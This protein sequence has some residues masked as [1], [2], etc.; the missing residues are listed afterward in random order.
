MMMSQAETATS[1]MNPI[2]TAG[3][4]PYDPTDEL[5]AISTY[6]QNV[7]TMTNQMSDQLYKQFSDQQN[8]AASRGFAGS[9]DQYNRD[10]AKRT[11]ENTW[12][13]GQFTA[14]NQMEA[15]IDD[16]HDEFM[17]SWW[18]ILLSQENAFTFDPPVSGEVS[19]GWVG[20][21]DED[22][23]D[24]DGEDDDDIIDDTIYDQDDWDFGGMDGYS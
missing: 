3:L 2:S 15:D 7:G 12:L 21:D 22:Y 17:D 10:A 19:G 8:L 5:N 9:G 6:H 14:Q 1:A 16:A 24:P 18:E 11:F 23:N 20:G 4:N 13:T